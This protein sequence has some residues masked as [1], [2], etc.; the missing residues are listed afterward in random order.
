MTYK[1]TE[2]VL[3]LV[4]D[5]KDEGYSGTVE[6]TK[7]YAS[8][9]KD[10]LGESISVQLSG[11]CKESLYL[12]EDTETG[13]L[14]VVGRYSKEGSYLS[15]VGVVELIVQIAWEFYKAYKPRGYTMPFEFQSLFVKYGY[16]KAKTVE[17]YEEQ[18]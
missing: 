12:V 2:N 13:E 1:I 6:I 10:I 9:T 4:Q 15:T 7:S 3:K 11:F 8:G 17:V 16:L 5:L 18:E 14:V